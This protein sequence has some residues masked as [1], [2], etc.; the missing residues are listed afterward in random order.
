MSLFQAEPLLCWLITAVLVA[1]LLQLALSALP[2][3]SSD[4]GVYCSVRKLIYSCQLR[5]QHSS[6]RKEVWLFNLH[7]IDPGSI[8]LFT[9]TVNGVMLSLAT[10]D[11]T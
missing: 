1:L 6:V 2:A 11:G 3:H 7:E 10:F 4:F 5:L 9:P 8:R